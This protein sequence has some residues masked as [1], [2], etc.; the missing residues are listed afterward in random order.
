MML[1]RLL[2]RL[3]ARGIDS[4]VISLSSAGAVAQRLARDTI[5]IVAL[6]MRA[7][8]PDPAGVARLV[9]T[10]R[11]LRPDVVQTWLYHSDLLGALAARL[12]GSPPVA[13]NIR[14]AELDP[15]DHPRTLPLLLRVL[16]R[17]SRWPAAIV[18]N[19]EAGRRAH[20]RL[21]YRPRRWIVIP[22][23]F[24]LETMCPR[25]HAAADLRHELGLPADARLVGLLARLHP[26]KDHPT[27]LAAAAT[28]AA[29]APD[30]HF[31]LAGRGVAASPALRDQVRA[32]GLQSRA[33]L[34]DERADPAALLS[35]LTVA[36]SASYSEAF[37]N[38]IA[39]AMACGTPCVATDV[40]DTRTVVGDAGV[41]VPA[42]DPGALARGVLSVLALDSREL[43]A[44][45]RTSRERIA[46]HFSLD[47][48]AA[49]YARAYRQMA[50]AT[51]VEGGA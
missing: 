50:G 18:T 49:E 7:G 45:Q 27:F 46:R 19:S 34:L 41:L 3:R 33:H 26:M 24:D 13:W 28:I 37:P 20:E 21:G 35:G 32:L 43:A 23:G 17:M 40:G 39:E 2:P 4:T 9:Q 30:V 25:P 11:R 22:N 5:P 48:V 16:A 12:A 8:F 15:R 47:T 51:I 42:R 31:V 38:V 10:L 29:A 6:G 1:A 14:C 44:L 36:V